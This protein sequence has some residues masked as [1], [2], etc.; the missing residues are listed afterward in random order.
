MKKI[1]AAMLGMRRNIKTTIVLLLCIIIGGGI[2]SACKKAEKSKE[3]LITQVIEEYLS[4]IREHDI[5]KTREL[6]HG[7]AI[8]FD[9]EDEVLLQIVY[10]P[11]DDCWLNSI[12]FPDSLEDDRLTVTVHYT[13]YS[14][15]F[16][17]G[18][19]KVSG[20][21]QINERFSIE[22]RNGQFVITGIETIP[23]W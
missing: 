8:I 1:F 6:I 2:F 13:I 22:K 17:P 14:D 12:E 23:D 11:I 10:Y 7:D 21:Q 5:T 16:F 19:H 18:G 20:E 9:P 4:S 15:D 3:E